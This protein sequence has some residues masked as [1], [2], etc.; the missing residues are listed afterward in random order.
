MARF[1][2]KN[3]TVTLKDGG[4]LSM[5]MGPGD[6]D[7]S[8]DSI[9][10]DNSEATPVMDR[11]VFDGFV[12]GP[13]L[14]QGFSISLKMRNESLTDGAQDRILD[15][16]R[17][18]GL[19]A[20][21]TTKDPSGTKWALQV[22]VDMNDGSNTGKITLPCCRLTASISEGADGHTI[23]ISGTNYQAPSYA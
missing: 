18:T 6:G 1:T 19:W 4:A 14:Q 8:I 13:D 17:K 10:E 21:G 20:A 15:V 7:V 2:S 23:S 11:G 22:E 3:T 12:E 16:V 5:L 9:E